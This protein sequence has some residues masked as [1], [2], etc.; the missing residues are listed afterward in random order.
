MEFT[1]KPVKQTNKLL[2][3]RVIGEK[4]HQ[5]DILKVKS[6]KNKIKVKSG[7]KEVEAEGF[8]RQRQTG[9]HNLGRHT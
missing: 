2:Q 9:K 8:F 1:Y 5:E 7:K 4:G 3:F 6:E